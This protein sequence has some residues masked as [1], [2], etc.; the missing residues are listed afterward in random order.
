VSCHRWG[1]LGPLRCGQR[2]GWFVAHP[3]FARSALGF[4]GHAD[5]RWVKLPGRNLPLL[6]VS[7]VRNHP[8]SAS[9]LLTRVKTAKRP[10]ICINC[11]AFPEVRHHH[12]EVWTHA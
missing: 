12:H 5:G 10:C 1:T 7:T 8:D 9:V 6:S 3:W 4:R 11:R 2:V